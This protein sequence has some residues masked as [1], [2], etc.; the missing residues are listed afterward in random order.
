VSL[1]EFRCRLAYPS[2]FVLDCSF[3]LH[4]PV[5][6]LFGH[7]GCGKTS[8]L[9]VIAGLRRPQQGFVRLGERVLEQTEL[10]IHLPPESR[11]VGY[12]FQDYL[13]FPHL[14]VRDNLCYGQRRRSKD[15]RPVEL[16]RVVEV[17]ELEALLQRQPHTLSGGQRQRVALGRALLSGPELLLLDEPLAS[18]DQ[19]LKLRVL[20]YIEEVLKEWRIPTLYAT[21]DLVEAR[22]LAGDAVL[23]EQGKVKQQGA[24]AEILP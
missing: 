2:G 20:D 10:G 17:L 15:A 9:S 16:K 21:H 1:L 4:E 24:P 6:V 7:S 8:I 5:T 13:L 22:K 3:T 23:L 11:H 14:S 19:P 12:V 18:V